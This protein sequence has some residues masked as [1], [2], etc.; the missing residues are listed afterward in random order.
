MTC[1]ECSKGV[2][3]TILGNGITEPPYVTVIKC[4]FDDKFYKNLD[5][6]CCHQ[7]D[8]KETI[9]EMMEEKD[10]EEQK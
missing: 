3:K 1:E 7:I 10:V 8:L 6:E 2:I 9:K 4:P 5:D